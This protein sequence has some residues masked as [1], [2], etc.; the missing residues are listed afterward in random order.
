LRG[1]RFEAVV[2]ADVL[3]RVGDAT[4]ILCHVRDALEP[5]GLVFVTE[6]N[7]SHVA[8]R[9]AL[10]TGRA[11]ALFP[12]LDCASID[13]ALRSVGLLIGGMF[14]Q[15]ATL[16]DCGASGLARLLPADLVETLARAPEAGTR[17]FVF[18]AYAAMSEVQLLH[19][20]G[21]LENQLRE[22]GERLREVSGRGDELRSVFGDD[23]SLIALRQGL[24]SISR[25]L[26][27]APVF[28]ATNGSSKNGHGYSRR[29][30]PTIV[31]TYRRVIDGLREVVR[32][33]IPADATVLV[34]SRGDDELVKLDGRRG[35]HFPQAPSGVYAGHHPGGS[36][37]AI[38]HLEELRNRGAQFLIFPA[39]SLWWLTHYTG[40]KRH[41]DQSHE[42]ILQVDE[43]CVVYRLR[44]E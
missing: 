27:A 3:G 18:F 33:S 15:E 21:R 31:E 23:R 35:W 16:A 5:G 26:T 38:N 30:D 8:V 22:F 4:A 13:S 44:Q 7:P 43:V 2:F 14:R 17:R 6:P 37:E 39:T 42:A 34:V 36:S 41:L 32:S 25:S 19:R 1:E 29:G 20:L 11:A 40:F 28:A 10:L 12:A 9:V 24:A